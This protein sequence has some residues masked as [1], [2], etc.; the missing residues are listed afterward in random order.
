MA[1]WFKFYENGMDEARFRY[2]LRTL[3]AV[4]PVWLL[5]LSECC[6][7]KSDT[8]GWGDEA[9]LLGWADK[10]CETPA[11]VNEAI[12]LL[13]KIRYIEQG[14]GWLRVRK[15]ND[16]QSDYCRKKRQ[17]SGE[18]PT[19]SDKV[20]QNP[21]RGEER[22]VEESIKHT[23]T[24]EIPTEQEVV[25]YGEMRGVLPES[26]KRFYSHHEDNSLWIN[27]HGRL[28][29]WRS[30]VVSWA[31][32]DRQMPARNGRGSNGQP[33]GAQIIA[34]QKELDAVDAERTGINQVYTGMQDKRPEDIKRLRELKDRRAELM[35]LLGRKV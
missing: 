28:I 13:V 26:A 33:N 11:R 30:K 9:D 35:K 1:D 22:R 32:R 34:W 29:N 17:H 31:A 24:A 12:K 19:K 3:S 5:I 25:T 10:A 8:V 15:W 7:T 21:S 2:A 6:R 23:H 27:Q 20:R 4:C 16:L 14:E 18:C